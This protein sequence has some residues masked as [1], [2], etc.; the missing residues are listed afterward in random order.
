MSD[1]REGKAC[2]ESGKELVDLLVF[3]EYE[4]HAL[5]SELHWTDEGQETCNTECRGGLILMLP[6]LSCS[7]MST[8]CKHLT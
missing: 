8:I 1:P 2:Q 3:R 6:Q 7:L 4:E 5:C